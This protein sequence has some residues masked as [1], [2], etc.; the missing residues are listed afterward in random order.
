MT[1]E[2]I[3]HDITLAELSRL[4]DIGQFIDCLLDRRV[5]FAES[6]PLRI[7]VEPMGDEA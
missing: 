6:N 3:F 4:G 1:N 7:H 5:L 2:L